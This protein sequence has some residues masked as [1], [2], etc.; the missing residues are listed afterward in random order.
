MQRRVMSITMPP[1]AEKVL[2]Q[3]QRQ[4]TV[5][6]GKICCSLR[7]H[8]VGNKLMSMSVFHATTCFMS[9]D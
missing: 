8:L 6:R 3:R 4:K 9:E 1:A 2:L 5:Q 7:R